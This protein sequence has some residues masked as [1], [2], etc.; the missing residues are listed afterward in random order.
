MGMKKLIYFLSIFL[1]VIGAQ[2]Q[3]DKIHY[4]GNLRN[5]NGSP[6]QNRGIRVRLSV[7]DS[8]TSGSVLFSETQTTTTNAGGQFTVYLGGGTALG[9]PFSA[10]PWE[11][12]NKKYLKME[13]DPNGGSNYQHFGTT[14]L[15]SVPYVIHAKSASEIKEGAIIRGNNGETYQISIGSNGP[16]WNCNPPVTQAS[17]GSDQLNLPGI[18]FNLS[19]NSPGTG[20]TGIWSKISGNTGI[21][22]SSTSYNSSFIRGNDSIYTLEWKIQGG[23]GTSRDTVLL[24]FANLIENGSCLGETQLTYSGTS[25]PIVRIGNA[26][27]MAKNLNVGNQVNGS[28]G[29]LNNGVIEKFCYNDLASNCSTYG[30]MYQWAEA[31]QYQ[32]GASNTVSPSPSFSSKLQGICPTGWHLPN[33]QDW[34]NLISY[35]DATHACGTSGAYFNYVGGALKSLNNWNSPNGGA[36]NRSGFSAVSNGYFYLGNYS[37]LGN[38]AGFWSTQDQGN[39]ATYFW[40]DYQISGIGIEQ[41]D[42]VVG[43][44]VRCVKDTLCAPTPSSAGPDQLS[45]SGTTATLA[46]NAPAAGETG[47]WSITTGSGGSLSSSNNP[48]ATFTKGTDSAYT[49]VWTI[50]GPCGTSRDTVNLRFPAPVG[51]ACGQTVTYA[52]ESYPTVQIGT[53]CWFA[54]NLNVGTM[55]NGYLN[56]TNNSILEKYCI[57]DDPTNCAIYGGFYQWAE[58]VQYQNGASNTTNPNP[59]FSGNIRGICP[60]GWHIPS[61]AEWYFLESTLGGSNYAGM[62]MKS[63]SNLWIAPNLGA[64]N[65]SGF[66]V[67]PS[68]IKWSYS[69]SITQIGQIAYFWST[70][71]NGPFS[72]ITRYLAYNLGST[73]TYLQDKT[74]GMPLRCLKDTL[75]GSTPSSAGPD[76]LNISGTTATLAGNAPGTGEI[77]AWSVVVGSGGR[78]SST[79]SPIATFSKGIDSAYTLV[80]TITGPCQ[81]SSD[82]VEF[83]FQNVIMN[84]TCPGI[85]TITYSSESYPTVQI[86]SQCWLAKNLNIGSI[87]NSSSAIDSQINNGILEKYCYDNDPANCTIYGGLYQWA[88]AVQYQNGASNTNFPNPS[89]L[90]NVRGICPTGWHIPSDSEWILLEN[91]LGGAYYSGGLLKTTNNLW[92]SPNYATNASGFSAL[93]SGYRGDDGT[94]FGKSGYSYFWSSSESFSNIGINRRLVYANTQSYKDN[95]SKTVGFSVRC[96]KD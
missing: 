44:A 4:Q 11:N 5:S 17:A 47:A 37:G 59:I 25:Y 43:N 27:W 10:I 87:K 61:D 20:N 84:T 48:T 18:I 55:I 28:V 72:A 32:N 24:K 91:N 75:C 88:E 65:S 46:A 74:S 67:L 81:S 54:K 77:G 68:G 9:N 8:I 26:C 41:G 13:I 30:G 52:G 39:L 6:L 58:A 89:F 85:P 49:L 79:S 80:W 57:N 69:G 92:G 38:D 50:T 76:Q 12:G 90:G 63:T 60:T 94:F 15:V 45:L 95:S 71:E 34:C 33:L 53:Q 93:P 22:D 82:T 42:K 3:P 66:S 1:S 73:L 96:L 78:F 70:N 21:L 64:T 86:G 23:C 31:V 40:M 14:L 2:A 56:Q 7:L 62:A 19:G 16:V 36:T 51:T 83:S 29:Q 35:Y